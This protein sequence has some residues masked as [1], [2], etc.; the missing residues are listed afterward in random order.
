MSMSS[1][2]NHCEFSATQTEEN[3]EV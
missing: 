3:E 1:Y 2:S